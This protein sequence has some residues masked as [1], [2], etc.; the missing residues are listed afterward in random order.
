VGTILIPLLVFAILILLPFI[1]RNR[2]KR[3]IKRPLATG[4]LV[5]GILGLG[6]LTILGVLSPRTPEELAMAPRLGPEHLSQEEQAGMRLYTDSGCVQCHSV[7]GIG[8]NVGPD[9]TNVRSGRDVSWLVNHIHSPQGAIEKT[10]RPAFAPSPENL[11][12]LALYLVRLNPTS[13]AVGLSGITG[14][15]LGRI[16][17]VREKCAVC[18]EI[19]FT[20]PVLFGVS[21]RRDRKYLIDHFKDPRAFV[22]DSKMPSFAHLPEEELNALVDYLDTLK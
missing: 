4:G 1:D 18:H 22:R 13:P 21:N 19:D 20:G 16:V 5:L 12:A 6:V 11:K 8:G 7:G 9:L 14:A 17:Y 3:P 2:D 10:V 15:E